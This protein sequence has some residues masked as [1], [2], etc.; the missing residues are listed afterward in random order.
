MI[1][2]GMCLGAVAF[3]KLHWLDSGIPH[4]HPEWPRL[5]VRA[6]VQEPKKYGLSD[7]LMVT[8]ENISDVS[9]S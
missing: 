6:N 1:L 5:L 9:Q 7:L 3:S 4:T 8:T 2:F